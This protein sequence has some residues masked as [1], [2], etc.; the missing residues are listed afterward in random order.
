MV[1]L[2]VAEKVDD[3][4]ARF[5]LFTTCWNGLMAALVGAVPAADDFFEDEEASNADALLMLVVS[6]L[7][8]LA[9][10]HSLIFSIRFCWNKTKK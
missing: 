9:M 4:D 7:S 2:S 5:R 6:L 3:V 8:S 1:L 10:I